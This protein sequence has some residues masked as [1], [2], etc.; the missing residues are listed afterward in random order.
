MNGGQHR[1][2]G[3]IR[4]L[5][6][7]ASVSVL[8]LGDPRD[9]RVSEARDALADLGA[10]LEV[11]QPTGPGRPEQDDEDLQRPPDACAHFRSPALR[12]A[13]EARST[14]AFDLAHVEEVVMAQYLDLLHCPRV[15][16]RQKVD[17][18]YHEAMA[19][20]SRKGRLAHL[21]EAARFLHWERRLLGAFERMLV[22]GVG[23][24]RLLEPVH[25][26]G[27]VSVIP[28]G[29]ADELQPPAR[30]TR[31]VRHV[32]L[33]GALDYGPNVEALRWFFR[34]VWPPLRVAAPEI[35][36]V[37]AG[38]GRLPLGA[39]PP[40]SD[41]RVE[42]RG[43]VPDVRSVLQA[44]GVLVVA[45]RVGGGAR[46]KILE[47]LACGMPVVSTALGVENLD[48]VAER[49]YLPAET[50]AETVTAIVRLTRE[51]ALVAS[52]GC[53]GVK[54]AE[55]FRWS[56]VDE[57]IEPIYREVASRGSRPGPSRAV[58]SPGAEGWLRAEIARLQAEREGLRGGPASRA[59]RTLRRWTRR[60]RRSSPLVRFEALAHRGLVRLLR[61]G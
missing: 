34:E 43:F 49:D 3:L 29:I 39:G 47:A 30:G 31:D 57:L 44:P 19:R 7:S 33:Y 51:P 22:P 21:G 1:T 17:W 15:I 14:T 12:F 58:V 2:L 32:L 10:T 60:L 5:S 28:I 4:C 36:V 55:R 11:Y 9:E 56:R 26:S 61:R 59:T 23:D 25:G 42:L 53:E 40:R 45:V 16:D 37:V 38:S 8:A 41:P 50:A 54:R 24:Q 18:A 13:L 6:R 35:K 20:V 52:L 46:T 48:L 27:A